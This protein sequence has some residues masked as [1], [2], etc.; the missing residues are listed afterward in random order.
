MPK[1]AQRGALP[2][3]ADPGSLT[4]KPTG[5]VWVDL[6]QSVGFAERGRLRR[7][8]SARRRELPDDRSDSAGLLCA[9]D[10]QRRNAQVR[11]E[12]RARARSPHARFRRCAVARRHRLARRPDIRDGR[13]VERRRAPAVRDRP[14]MLL[15]SDVRSAR[16]GTLTVN[17]MLLMSAAL[18]SNVLTSS[19]PAPQDGPL[20]GYR[21]V[22]I[23]APP[24]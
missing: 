20:V 5:A 11:L 24:E 14:P 22:T 8:E 10:E 1:L 9:R 15:P 23:P 18:W 12:E 17:A 13:G 7:R 4:S 19:W 3:S 21:T 16:Q 2:T 6:G